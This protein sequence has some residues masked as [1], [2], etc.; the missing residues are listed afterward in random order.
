MYDEFEDC[1]CLPETD[2]NDAV[3]VR[4]RPAVQKHLSRHQIRR[5]EH[6]H[7]ELTGIVLLPLRDWIF[8]TAIDPDPEQL[9]LADE[10]AL[11]VFQKLATATELSLEEKRELYEHIGLIAQGHHCVDP[12][13]EISAD[14]PDF[15]TIADMCR[16]ARESYGVLSVA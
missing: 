2:F 14:L 12:Q 3:S 1:S 11:S 10:A 8:S 4:V 9:I 13:K 7:H 15:T 6:L 5:I 16:Q